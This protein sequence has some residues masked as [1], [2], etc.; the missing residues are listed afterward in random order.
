ME[1][2]NYQ[3]HLSNHFAE[4]IKYNVEKNK[5]FMLKIVYAKRTLELKK[6]FKAKGVLELTK[7]AWAKQ[8]QKLTLHSK[9]HPYLSFH[10][11]L[12]RQKKKK[13]PQKKNLKKVSRSSSKESRRNRKLSYP[14]W[15]QLQLLNESCLLTNNSK[16]C[17]FQNKLQVMLENLFQYCTIK[18][19]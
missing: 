7:I 11:T 19:I 17:F 5:E 13:I 3:S 8:N 18:Q 12:Q 14:N 1:V 6:S 2:E 16:N 4:A 15:S 9:N 10:R